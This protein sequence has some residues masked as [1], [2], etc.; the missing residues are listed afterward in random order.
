M[1]YQDF[2][3]ARRKA[4]A[5]VIR[6]GFDKLLASVSMK[7]IPFMFLIL[8]LAG[9]TTTSTTQSVLTPTSTNEPAN[10]DI[11]YFD[12]F[13]IN[14]INWT[15]KNEEGGRTYYSQGE[16][17]IIDYP[18]DIGYCEV[19]EL[20]Q[21]DAVVN[22]EVRQISGNDDKGLAGVLYRVSENGAYGLTLNDIGFYQIEK[23][24]KDNNVELQP[25]KKSDLLLPYGKTNMVTV[26]FY[27]ENADFFINN[28]FIASI[29]DD[30]Y[31]LGFF[32]LC[33]FSDE[34][35][36][37]YAFDN[38]VIYRYDP[39]NAY[40]PIRP[41]ST[42]TPSY[43]S[44][45]W[46]ELADFIARDHTNWKPYN[47]NN[48]V[49]L[50]YAIDLVENARKENIKAWIVGVDF[51]NGEIGHAFVAFETSDKGIRYVEPQTDYTYS[52]LTI[53]HQLCDDWGQDECWGTIAS[54][55][56]FSDCD[57]DQYC[58]EFEP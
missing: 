55:T 35:P 52:D 27:G 57:H 30:S 26:S 31:A 45:T 49:C 44:I 13:S 25:W 23:Y 22:V 34:N 15:E 29:S 21:K 58:T 38:L 48:Y 32:E 17:H 40:T 50:D 19:V 18:D 16:Y 47:I 4:M 51:T 7:R 12:D 8:L 20:V 24:L 9:C 46:K 2:L 43:R 28:N 14:S 11:L 54:I 10:S 56:H 41:E 1:K 6:K 33:V 37:E 3:E 36:V 42:P 53:G 5:K 39:A